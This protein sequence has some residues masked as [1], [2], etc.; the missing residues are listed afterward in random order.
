MKALHL[1]EAATM[2]VLYQDHFRRDS[3]PRGFLGLAYYAGSGIL[4]SQG[5]NY[6]AGKAVYG[7]VQSIIAASEPYP[8]E[9]WSLTAYTVT[10]QLELMFTVLLS[11]N[12]RVVEAIK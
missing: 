10:H 2:L 3:S 5:F 8:D 12:W 7:M 9:G 6:P 4:A 11:V 1:A